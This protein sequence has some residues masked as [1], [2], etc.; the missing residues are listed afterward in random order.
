MVTGEI[1]YPWVCH[2]AL[3]EAK[4]IESSP[5]VFWVTVSDIRVR[6]GQNQLAI[7]K[8]PFKYGFD[9]IALL[10]KFIKKSL[11]YIINFIVDFLVRKNIVDK[12][13]Q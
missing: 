11:E 4:V 10:L 12:Q 8:P 1:L 2:V 9:C 13:H 7:H 5:T 6:A 3:W